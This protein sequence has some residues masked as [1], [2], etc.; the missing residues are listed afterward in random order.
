MDSTAVTEPVE[1]PEMPADS[2]QSIQD[3][4]EALVDEAGVDS[5]MSVTTVVESTM[6]EVIDAK[7]G[8]DLGTEVVKMTDGKKE[9]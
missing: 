8:E 9:E 2:V 1:V 6:Q 3:Q 4:W 5:T 7:V